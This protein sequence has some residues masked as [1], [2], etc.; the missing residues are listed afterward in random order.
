[1][2]HTVGM[3]RWCPRAI[4]NAPLLA[5]VLMGGAAAASSGCTRDA[6]PDPE[7]APVA[8][9]AEARPDPNAPP[10]DR[11]EIRVLV[12]AHRD[13]PRSEATR[14]EE[15]AFERAEM[16]AKLAKGGDPLAELV[17]EYSDRPDAKEDGGLFKVRTAAP[18]PF[19]EDV[20]AAALALAPGEISNPV[21]TADGY[22]V[23]E[24][25]PDP[26]PGPEQIAARHILIAYAGSPRAVGDTTRT[27]AE[28]RALA[29]R[30]AREAKEPDADWNALAAEHTDEPGSG[31]TG[32]DLG[33]FGRGQMVPSFEA[34]AFELEVGEVSDAVQSP[35]GFHVILRYE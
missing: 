13:V 18:D 32:G 7:P 23:I 33:R 24:R 11:I 10:P 27:E 25:R 5:F 21:R 2:G 29:E 4:R 30:V 6:R 12:V 19:D 8:V 3:D 16:L 28:A 9:E 14:T 34:V 17:P 20:V 31:A 26:L 15:Q 1:M 35:F 22:V